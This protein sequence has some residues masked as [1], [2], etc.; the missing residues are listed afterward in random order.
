[1]AAFIQLGRT[2]DCFVQETAWPGHVCGLTQEEHAAFGQAVRQAK[3]LNGW[4][5]EEQVRHALKGIAYLLR[6]DA[7][8]AWTRN[9]PLLQAPVEPMRVGI[10]MAG[11][12]PWVGFHDLLCVLLAGHQAVVK[13]SSED[14]GLTAALLALLR[15][16]VPELA[17]AVR[18]APGKLGEVDALIATGSN[19]TSRYFQH[20]FALV[21]RLVRKGRTSVAVLDGSES[22]RELAALGEDVFRYFGLGCRNVGMLWLPRGFDLD[23]LFGAFYPWREVIHHHKYANNYDYNKAIWLLDRVPITE[24]GFLLL[25]E[26]PAVHSPVAALHYQWYDRPEEPAA[27]LKRHAEELQCVVGHGHV[28]FGAAQL[29][30]PDDYADGVDTLAF[31]LGPRPT[32]GN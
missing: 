21:P 17:A 2:L 30:G 26:D 32:A 19:N 9:Y 13:P 11:N 15:T 5:T 6:P 27:A 25:K 18:L 24:N 12:I 7:L 23:R 28:P 16:L 29:P 3:A 8:E 20:Y 14:A 4:F 1:M 10:I 31:L 22:E